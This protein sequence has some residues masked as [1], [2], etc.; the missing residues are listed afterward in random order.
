[1]TPAEC[2]SSESLR[3]LSLRALLGLWLLALIFLGVGTGQI[4]EG[5][6]RVTV[7]DPDGRSVAARIELVS[8]NPLFRTEAQADSLGQVRLLRISPGVYRLVV[9][10]AGFEEYVD[11]VEIRSAVPQQKE[12]TLKLAAVATEITVQAKVPLLDPSQ[13]GQVM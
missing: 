2:L 5:E 4:M 8:R 9:K 3:Q 6:L 1:M 13:P 12:I 7:R 10:S 11:T